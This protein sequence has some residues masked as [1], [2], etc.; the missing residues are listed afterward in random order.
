MLKSNGI[1][2]KGKLITIVYVTHHRITYACCYYSKCLKRDNRVFSVHE[3]FTLRMDDV[4]NTDLL[5]SV[6]IPILITTLQDLL[7]QL[8]KSGDYVGEPKL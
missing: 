6:G 3:V 7:L 2:V 8:H 4:F 1:V 5:H